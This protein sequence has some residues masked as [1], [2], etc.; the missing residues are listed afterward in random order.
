MAVSPVTSPADPRADP[1]A[2][3]APAAGSR[4]RVVTRALLGTG[5]MA[6]A[7]GTA[8]A[9]GQALN[10]HA[11]LAGTARQAVMAAIC[12]TIAVSLIVLLR[13]GL[14]RRPLSGLGFP[15]ILTGL[16]TFALGVAVT[17]GSAAVLFGAGTWAGWL[18]WG[19]LDAPALVRFLIVNAVIALALEALPEELVFRGYVY[20]TLNRALRRWTAF[21][22]TVVL[23]TFAGAASSVVFAVVG[24]LLGE[25]VPGPGFAPSGEDPV[26]YAILYP[27]FGAVLLIARITTGSLWTAI[28]MHLTYLT[29]V[30]VALD[31]AS[32]D[33]G[34]SAELTTPDAVL[35]VPGFLLLAAL[36]YL[37]I[38]RL[39]RRRPGWRE[40]APE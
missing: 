5:A 40:R 25:D 19:P 29:V 35:L 21:V 2:D 34:W 7:L 1:R 3:A 9:I 31:G 38:G 36:G 26:E 15:G 22:A 28:G 12:L 14:D 24:A 16:R 23:F 27:I 17:A 11:G 8:A 30:R 20:R 10:S 18:D 37:V 4:L 13:R 33:A 39:R 32:R 6:V